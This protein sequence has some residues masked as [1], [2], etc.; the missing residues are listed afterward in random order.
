MGRA[1][2]AQ[3]LNQYLKER[4]L[5]TAARFFQ[6]P[7]RS[8]T[9]PWWHAKGG[10]SQYLWQDGIARVQARRPRPSPCSTASRPIHGM[11]PTRRAAPR[12]GAASV[13]AAGI[14][15]VVHASDGGG[16][17][18]IPRFALRPVWPQ[19]QPRPSAPAGPAN[20]EG[21]MGLSMNHVISRSVRD[22]AHLLDL[23]Q[24][25]EPARAPCRR[26][27]WSSYLDALEAVAQEAQDRR[28]VQELLWHSRACGLSGCGGQ[29]HQRPAWR[30]GMK[31][32]RT[33]RVACG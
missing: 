25:R 26:A 21:W 28:L 1:L 12:S 23:T 16:S 6:G 8:T 15:P 19:A 7:W 4:S 5:P 30:W 9:V 3:D 11:L 20:M 27:T 13:V 31:S 14:V 29:G 32:W 2:S 17:I 10:R 18:R 33:C 24:G 22:S